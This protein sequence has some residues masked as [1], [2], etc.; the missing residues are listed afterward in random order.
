MNVGESHPG[1]R[2]NAERPES[3]VTVLVVDDHPTVR[4]GITHSL[5]RDP[6]IATLEAEDMRSAQGVW[7]RERPDL[8]LIDLGLPDGDGETLLTWIRARDPDAVC[9][10][11]TTHGGG[12]TV[13]RVM[14]SGARGFL[15]KD[16][17]PENLPGL[18]R[19]A[20]AG[21][22]VVSPEA[23]LQL[24]RAMETETLTERESEVLSLL[25]LGLSN[26]RLAR[27]LGISERTVKSHMGRILAK[28]GAEDRTDALVKAVLRGLV[29]L[30]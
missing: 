17:P 29:R 24:R 2:G 22:R 30:T 4:L 23:E 27:N 19:D 6:G 9:V 3:P 18:V 12:E 8:T 14:A 21:R 25:A 7:D 10:V 28:L 13:K 11:L 1:G 26:R 5:R 16:I 20:L 15:L